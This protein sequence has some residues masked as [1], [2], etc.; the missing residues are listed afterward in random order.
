LALPIDACQPGASCHTQAG[1]DKIAGQNLPQSGQTGKRMSRFH[2][3][4]ARKRLLG[5]PN[6]SQNRYYRAEL[7]LSADIRR[8]TEADRYQYNSKS[9]SGSNRTTQL[10]IKALFFVQTRKLTGGGTKLG[11]DRATSTPPAMPG[12]PAARSAATSAT[13]R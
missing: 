8:R 3:Y 6:G 9:S 13:P 11:C 4:P 5:L 10:D 2:F 1:K 12:L 7:L